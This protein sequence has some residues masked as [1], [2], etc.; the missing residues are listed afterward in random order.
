MTATRKWLIAEM[1]LLVVVSFGCNPLTAPFYFMGAPYEKVPPEFSLAHPPEDPADPSGKDR[2]KAPKVAVLVTAAGVDAEFRG[3]ER[4]L[5]SQFIDR[6]LQD[7][8]M[9]KEAVV[10]LPRETVDKFRQNNP[11][12]KSLSAK[13]IGERLG[14][15]FMIDL[16]VNAMSMYEP[17]SRRSLY[18][19]QTE[20]AVAVSDVHRSS[21]EP[22]FQK[23]YTCQY[24]NTQP[25]IADLDSNRDKFKQEFLA[26]VVTDL[27][28]LFTSHLTED[29]YHRKR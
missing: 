10:V 12:W 17:G 25:V 14:V 24:P 4:T 15:D 13:E 20:I 23:I 19:G 11:S 8:R 5:S 18:R 2:G 28:W 22:V 16:E 26:C 3:V 9:N 21:D 1:I 29:E 6:L 7:C 27:V